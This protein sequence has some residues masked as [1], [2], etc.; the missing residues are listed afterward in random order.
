MSGKWAHFGFCEFK[1]L[2]GAWRAV[3]LLNGRQ[4][5]SRKLVVKAD[6]KVQD[7]ITD[8]PMSQRVNAE[9]EQRTR[10]TMDALLTNVNARWREAALAR[11]AEIQEYASA[12]VPRSKPTI[13][14]EK[15][16]DPLPHWY[17]ESRREQDRIRR[18]DRRKR[19]RL[20]DFDRAMRDWEYQEK[21]IHRD[22]LKDME[23]PESVKDMKRK[24]INQDCGDERVVCGFT[25]SDR[26]REVE[27]DERDRQNEAKEI[28][29]K[30]QKDESEL[31]E[32]STR[33]S[34]MSQGELVRS[35]ASSPSPD[36]GEFPTLDPKIIQITRKIPTSLDSIR[37]I[38]L[39]WSSVLTEGTLLKLRSW[40][41]RKLRKLGCSDDESQILSRY[42]TKSLEVNARSYEEIFKCVKKLER[43]SDDVANEISKKC[44]QLM[45]F[46]QL[47]QQS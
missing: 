32:L 8:F 46:T 19:N 30:R 5:G 12:E 43:L 2:E 45:F 14:E 11:D 4:L 24:L 13:Q 16:E 1:R 10:A 29:Q 44:M 9:N 18:I 23:D 40:L 3:E 7:R 35:L 27:A 31:N 33:L 39:E 34:Q 38:K 41:R 37:N 36:D 20:E 15:V 21:R 17:R 42:V 26:A 28:E 47:V 25:S 6:S 22:I